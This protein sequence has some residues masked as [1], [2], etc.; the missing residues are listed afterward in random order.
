MVNPINEMLRWKESAACR[1]NCN[2]APLEEEVG[3]PPPFQ[4]TEILIPLP[5]A[6]PLPPAKPREPDDLQ[7][8]NAFLGIAPIPAP[9]ATVEGF[10]SVSYTDLEANYQ[11]MKSD[12]DTIQK[13][14][15]ELES[16]I[17]DEQIKQETLLQKD[18]VQKSFERLYEITNQRSES[19][20]KMFM[21][22]SS[23]ALLLI[24]IT[25][26]FYQ[27]FTPGRG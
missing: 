24:V 25:V 26:V 2:P 15:L 19:Y 13:K 22:M 8:Y 6:P 20:Q 21:T 3:P 5:M 10:T 12:V 27:L 4:E 18:A 23:V 1:Q 16:K 11:K 17:E 14:N 7:K 9:G